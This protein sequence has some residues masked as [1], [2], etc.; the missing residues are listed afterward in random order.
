[1]DA[2]VLECFQIRLDP[3]P[4]R[5]IRASDGEGGGREVGHGVLIAA[6]WISAIFF[7]PAI[8]LLGSKPFRIGDHPCLL[9]LEIRWPRWTIIKSLIQDAKGN[10]NR[11][12]LLPLQELGHT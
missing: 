1:M 12:L 10:W 8:G 4:G 11:R 3:G 9:I 2:E 5:T 6:D 7:R